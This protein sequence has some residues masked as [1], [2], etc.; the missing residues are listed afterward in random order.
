[1]IEGLGPIPGERKLLAIMSR[2]VTAGELKH[3]DYEEMSNS[4][5]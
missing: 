5:T 3:R 2:K 1:M 4:K